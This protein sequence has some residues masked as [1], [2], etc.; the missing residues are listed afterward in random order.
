[1]RKA[2]APGACGQ[3]RRHSSS[4]G[5]GR[6][7][8]GREGVGVWVGGGGTHRLEHCLDIVAAGPLSPGHSRGRP[9]LLGDRQGR[10]AEEGQEPGHPAGPKQA[11]QLPYSSSPIAIGQLQPLSAAAARAW[12][13]LAHLPAPNSQAAGCRH[14]ARSCQLPS[15]KAAAEGRSASTPPAL[16]CP[17]WCRPEVLGHISSLAGLQEG[18]VG[19]QHLGRGGIPAA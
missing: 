6:S 10:H 4:N 12:R 16:D 17:P 1:M 7:S 3:A 5:G 15:T 19:A 11:Q 13:R 9:V 2:Q 18:R 8:G 14:P